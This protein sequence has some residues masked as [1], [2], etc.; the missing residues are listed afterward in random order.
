VYFIKTIHFGEFF[1]CI[2]VL[3]E[4][5]DKYEVMSVFTKRKDADYDM[6][7]RKKL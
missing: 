6:K 2:F 4:L 5:N 7:R 1:I 3:K